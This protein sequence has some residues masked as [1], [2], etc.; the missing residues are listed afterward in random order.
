MKPEKNT[1]YK[2]KK[3]RKRKN[4]KALGVD[5]SLPLPAMGITDTTKPLKE[6]IRKSEKDANEWERRMKMKKEFFNK[7]KEG[8][9]D[10]STV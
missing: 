7:K 2:K 5:T 8:N 4:A 6:Q 1:G 10:A 3:D 9:K